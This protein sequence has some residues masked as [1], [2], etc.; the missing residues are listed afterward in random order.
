MKA[1]QKLGIRS[2]VAGIVFGVAAAGLGGCALLDSRPPEEVLKERAQQKWDALV[3]SDLKAAYQFL[4]P[5]SRAVLSSEAYA[6]SIKAGF[7]KSAQVERAVCEK[8][9]VCDVHVAIEY[10]HR[11]MRIKTPL[12]ETWIKEGS[13]WWFVQK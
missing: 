9:D 11:G 3:K 8:P 1:R 7:W 12:R 2:G 13:S 6:S 5:G 4:S 10:D